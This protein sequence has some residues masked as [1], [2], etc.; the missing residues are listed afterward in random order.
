VD[1]QALVEA[2]LEPGFYDHPVE[3]VEYLQT[4]ISSVFLTGDFVYKLKKPLDFGFLDYTTVELRRRFCEAEVELNRRLA[5]AVYLGVKP[6]TMVDGLPILDGA[7]EPVDWVVVMR[8]MDQRLLGPEVDA[9]GELTEAHIDALVD[10][11][12]P[13]YQDAATGPGVDEYG[14]IDTVKFN[15]DE[16]FE[17]TAGFVGEAIT[18]QQ[19]EEIR[20]YTDTFYERHAALFER[21]IANGYIRESHGDLHLRNIVLSSPPIIFDCIEFNERFRCGDVAVDLAFLAMDLDFRGHPGLARRLVNRYVR[22]SGD[23]ELLK[24]LDFYRCY[25]AYV[26]GKIACFTMADPAVD[27]DTRA[28]QRDLARRYF[29]LAHRY[30]HGEAGR[31]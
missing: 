30:A 18:E 10:I 3:S 17:Q 6:I 1:H 25:R 21:R 5:P 14:R 26:R 9:R 23:H 22:Q 13:F 7:G 31:A 2:M 16:N 29:D 12:V 11:L 19:Y 8:Q 28:Q 27:E 15:T 24:L 4:H 20:S